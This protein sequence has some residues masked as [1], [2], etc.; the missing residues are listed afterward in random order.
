MLGQRLVACS[1]L[2]PEGVTTVKTAK[3]TLAVGISKGH[4][5]AISNVCRHQFA[6]LGRGR[7]LSDGSLMCPW[8]R[9]RFDVQTGEMISGPKG[10]VYG[11]KSYSRAVK[12]YACLPPL[13]L[14]RYPVV[15]EDGVIY[16]RADV[17]TGP[18]GVP[19]GGR[20]FPPPGDS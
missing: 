5:F 7:V 1:E 12:A 3:G 6:A 8:H 20:R 14:K 17:A 4:P 19:G 9:A 13:R 11:F 15:E 16:L 2:G 18:P 10:R